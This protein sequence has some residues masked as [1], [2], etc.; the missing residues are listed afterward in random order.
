MIICEFKNI[1]KMHNYICCSERTIRR[2]ITAGHIF[3]PIPY[4]KYLKTDLI[5]KYNNVKDNDISLKNLKLKSGVI[6]TYDYLIKFK[7]TRIKDK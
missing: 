7:V 4:V 3:I 5:K 2:S 6:K 1:S